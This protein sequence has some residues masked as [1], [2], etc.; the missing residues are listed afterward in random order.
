[1]KLDHVAL[2]SAGTASTIL[3]AVWAQDM[4]PCENSLPSAACE[5]IFSQARNGQVE[6]MCDSS[7]DA[8]SPNCYMCCAKD[9]S[10][11]NVLTDLVV[12]CNEGGDGYLNS[13]EP[14]GD[15][16]CENSMGR[17]G[18][19]CFQG[20]RYEIR[21]LGC[22]GCAAFSIPSDWTSVT[23]PCCGNVYIRVADDQTGCDQIV[24][25]TPTIPSTPPPVSSAISHAFLFPIECITL[26]ATMLI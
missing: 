6:G 20:I 8:L 1:M 2:V 9:A 7:V 25:V 22:E 12:R 5:T 3:R 18:Q 21:D 19:M 23:F 26:L 17:Y 14:L 15:D 11:Y 16:A 10:R 4:I 13:W 24:T